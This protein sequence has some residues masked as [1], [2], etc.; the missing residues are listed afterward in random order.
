MPKVHRSQFLAIY[1]GTS[2]ILNSGTADFRH[3]RTFL[4]ALIQLF[5]EQNGFHLMPKITSTVL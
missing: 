4:H 2:G 1:M 5:Y 3:F